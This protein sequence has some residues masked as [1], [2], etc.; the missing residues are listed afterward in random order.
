MRAHHAR[1]ELVQQASFPEQAKQ[2]KHACSK[3]LQ[4]LGQSLAN[5]EAVF[6]SL[7]VKQGSDNGLEMQLC[8]QSNSKAYALMPE[9][10]RVQRVPARAAA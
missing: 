6:T 1:S 7:M 9:T 5:V 10:L 4:H 3:L 2:G 8:C